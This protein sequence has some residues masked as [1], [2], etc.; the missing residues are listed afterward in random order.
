[1]INEK[2]EFIIFDT[3]GNDSMTSTG[4]NPPGPKR[5]CLSSYM[6]L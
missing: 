4:S 3:L 5:F 2:I 1:M 6:Y